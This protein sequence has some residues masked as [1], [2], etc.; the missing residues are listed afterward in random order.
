MKFLFIDTE[1]TGLTPSDR[2]IQLAYKIVDPAAEKT[3]E[4]PLE[5][6]YYNPSWPVTIEAMSVH[7]ITDKMLSD[8]IAFQNSPEQIFL[9]E[10][11]RDLL[12]IA[13]NAPYDLSVLAREGVNFPVFIDTCKCAQHLIDS[14]NH[15]LQYLR[16]S[17]D[18]NVSGKAHDAEGDVNVLVAL[19]YHLFEIVQKEKLDFDA[20]IEEMIALS[21][22][23]VLLKTFKFGKYNGKSFDTMVKLDR[24]YLEWLY[25]Q[26]NQKPLSEQNDDLIHTLKFHLGCLL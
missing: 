8:K 4:S 6:N 20:T 26:E 24:G 10:N 18:L 16:Y 7:H 3:E 22:K 19:F 15:K 9:Q 21:T 5:M 17:L 2:L 25:K 1:T 14:P 12:F 13:H 23:P 11:S